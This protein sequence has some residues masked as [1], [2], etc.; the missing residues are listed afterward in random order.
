M[1]LSRRSVQQQSAT[2]EARDPRGAKQDHT[3]GEESTRKKRRLD[4]AVECGNTP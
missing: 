3:A 2:R 1:P 4:P